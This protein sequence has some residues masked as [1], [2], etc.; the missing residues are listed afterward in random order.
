MRVR[1]LDIAAALAAAVVIVLTAVAVYAPGNAAP[2]VVISGA[3]GEWIYPL[4]TNRTLQIPGPLGLTTVEIL[5]K[6]ARVTDSPCKNKICIAMG[7]ISSPGQWIAC[8]PNKVF[9]RV[10]G[11]TARGAADTG[12]Y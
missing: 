6:T 5:G 10:E 4:D 8:L 2:E 12:A 1:P 3:G 7:A 9:V 11:R